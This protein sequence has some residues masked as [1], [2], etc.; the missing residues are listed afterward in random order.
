[1]RRLAILTLV[2]TFV[3]VLL[4][5]SPAL[6]HGFGRT[7]DIPLPFWLYLFGI[8]AVVFATFVQVAMS[9]GKVHALRPYPRT[10]LLRNRLLRALSNSRSLLLGLRLLST[11]LLVLVILTGLFGLQ[12]PS[13]NFAPTFVWVI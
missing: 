4:A 3:L 10:D 12:D 2:S 7:Q 11:G 1:M 8:N 9:I 13:L 5:P 6:A